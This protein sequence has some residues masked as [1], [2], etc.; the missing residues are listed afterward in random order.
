MTVSSNESERA[1][2]APPAGADLLDELAAVLWDER[3]LLRRLHFQLVSVS[4]IMRS[5][6]WQWLSDVDR[7]LL[8]TSERLK[9]T[10]VLRAG[11]SLRLAEAV[12]ESCED[13]LGALSRAVEEPWQSILLDHDRALRDLT[14][15]VDDAAIAA[16]SWLGATEGF[17]FV[18]LQE[19][20]PLRDGGPGGDAPSAGS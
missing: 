11:L 8:V 10:E 14:V 9:R 15:A 5:G 12:G 6:D 17:D 20:F 18:D 13:A 4:L 3:D 7:D 1:A 19:R 2:T 16:E